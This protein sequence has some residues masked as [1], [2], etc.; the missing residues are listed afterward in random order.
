MS[1]HS[2]ILVGLF[3]V[4]GVIFIGVVGF[5]FLAIRLATSIEPMDLE[6]DR[7]QLEREWALKPR[8]PQWFPD[9]N[10]IAFSHEGGVYVV[11]TAG[12]SLLL[13]DG[14]GSDL[15]LAYAPSVSPDGTRIAYA[16]YRQTENGEG[17]EIM[18]AE[19]DGSD[20]R[21]LT[22]NHREEGN[23]IWTSDGNRIAFMYYYTS[24]RDN[25]YEEAGIYDISMDGSDLRLV[26]RF[27]DI[28]PIPNDRKGVSGSRRLPLALSP[29]G[30]RLA[31]VTEEYSPEFGSGLQSIHV[32]GVD[33]SDEKRLAERTGPPAW[34]P[35]SRRIAYIN[36]ETHSPSKNL[37]GL[38]TMMVDGTDIREVAKLRGEDF[39]TTTSIS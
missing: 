17:W 28:D 24:E 3:A 19:P 11:D 27:I 1:F 25:V 16:A 14:G 12:S 4:L 35:D 8:S 38:F 10:H 6:Y 33:G 39:T 21:Q 7:I 23:P 37:V 30:S 36:W 18:T 26:A 31:F 34:S 5:W 29:D 9:G 15:D 13:I 20:R 2:K 32:V 22:E